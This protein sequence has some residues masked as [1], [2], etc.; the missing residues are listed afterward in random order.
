MT[1]S[2]QQG[3][4]SQSDWQEIPLFATAELLEEYRHTPHRPLRRS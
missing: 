4:P 2:R 3:K 1:G